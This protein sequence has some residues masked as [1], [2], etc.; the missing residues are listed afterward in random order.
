MGW[1]WFQAAVMFAVIATNIH[2]KW[3]PNGYL[4][5]I[6]AAFA[7]WLATKLLAWALNLRTRE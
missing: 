7:A 6:I 2:W 4:A 1:L 5:A 3:T